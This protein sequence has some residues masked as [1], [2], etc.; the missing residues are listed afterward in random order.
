M[1]CG[2][3]REFSLNEKYN[4]A[5]MDCGESREFSYNAKYNN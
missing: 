3:C 4:N 2:K 5:T 1:H